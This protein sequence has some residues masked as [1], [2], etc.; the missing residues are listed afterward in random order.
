MSN[1]KEGKGWIVFA[2]IMLILGGIAM[3][4]MGL[5]VLNAG[6]QVKAAF[7]GT[8]I[9]SEG[10][11]DVWGWIYVIT[12]SIVA[13]AGIAVFSRAQWAVWTGIFAAGVQ[14]V[15]A[16]FFSFNPNFWGP[17]LGILIIDAL[18]IHGLCRYG[19]TDSEYD[20][21]VV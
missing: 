8:L 15:A 1:G 19:L 4:V 18:I 2:G 16:L 14:F 12:G 17:S 7:Q 11:L 10:N 9:A 6:D 21:A 13:I 20:S 3:L 5:A